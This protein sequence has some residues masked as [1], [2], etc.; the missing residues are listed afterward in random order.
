[1]V[2][3]R[4]SQHRVDGLKRRPRDKMVMSAAHVD[5]LKDSR[6]ES[7]WLRAWPVFRDRLYR[8]SVTYDQSSTEGLTAEDMVKSISTKYGPATYVALEIDFTKNDRYDVTQKPVASWEDT[9]YSYHLVRSSLQRSSWL[10]IYSK[11][12][13][14][15]AELAIIEAVKLEK[16]EGPQREAD[17]QKKQMDDL[18][19]ARQK[20]QKSF[21]P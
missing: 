7:N 1:M 20:N 18:E 10:I 2:C 6:A 12:V 4:R 19:V 9:L 21:R 8:I 13:N 17:R 11:L 15:E 16:Q 5:C 14:R 3:A